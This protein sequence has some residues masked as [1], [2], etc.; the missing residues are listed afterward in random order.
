MKAVHT[1]SSKA[2]LQSDFRTILFFFFFI[3]HQTKRREQYSVLP[4]LNVTNYVDLKMTRTTTKG[5]IMHHHTAH[6][7]AGD[8]MPQTSPQFQYLV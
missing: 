4:S 6:C 2:Y 7:Y 8:D 5:L 3:H 1:I